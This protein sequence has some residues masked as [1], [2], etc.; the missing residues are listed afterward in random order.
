MSQARVLTR[1]LG[2][3][4]LAALASRRGT[5]AFFLERPPNA[6]A[7]RARMESVRS[8]VATSWLDALGPAIAAGSTAAE[9]LR[10]VAEGRGVLVTTG[11]Q[12]GL[13]GGPLYTWTKAISALAL[14]DAL[15]AATGIPAAPLFWAATD[16]ADYAEASVTYVATRRGLRELRLPGPARDGVPM[17]EHPLG[18]VAQ[19]VEELALAAGSVSYGE[20]LAA[21]RDAYTRNPTVGGAY[22]AFVRRMFEPLGIAVLDASH[23]SVRG[24][25]RPILVEALRRAPELDAALREREVALRADGYEPQVS[26]VRDLSLVFEY[27]GGTKQRVPLPRARDVAERRDGALGPNV[28]L[29]PIVERTLLPAVAYAAGPGEL[30]YFA[31]AS[32]LADVLGVPAPLGVPR[33]S[34]LIVEPYVD[35]IL[36][37]YE[38][39][40]EDLRDPHGVTRERVA[41]RIPASV[42]QSLGALREAVR[43]AMDGVRAAIASD[44]RPLV[45]RRVVDGAEFQLQHRVDR[46]ERRVLAAAKRRE[47]DV[48][49]QVSAA[50]AALC[51]LGEPQERALNF[52]P[53]LARE[54]P[55]LLDSMRAAAGAHANGLIDASSAEARP[56]DQRATP[57]AT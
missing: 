51:P 50:H 52:V 17:A 2:G 5:N 44:Q 45:E 29:R 7:W 25:A 36:A 18:D 26:H 39:S 30:S 13:F 15:E 37:R 4:P 23:A 16:D 28:L 14:A 49:E 33:W 31:Q 1:P 40:I 54:G 20:P 42:T 46:L 34:A 41:K 6:A 10:R 19:L 43:R 47:T 24:A 38:L 9:R 3:S 12:P 27:V 53:M 8:R 22:L 48:V 57:M 21:V 11:Q 56:A 55:A 32:A 35:R